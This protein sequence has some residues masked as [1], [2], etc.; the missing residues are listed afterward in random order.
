MDAPFELQALRDLREI[1][2]AIRDLQS[3]QAITSKRFKEG[4]KLLQ[5]E[6]QIV[7]SQLND[8]TPTMDGTKAWETRN[9]ILRNLINNPRLENIPEE[10]LV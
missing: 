8:G 5:N 10:N 4:I 1:N 3:Q 9:P 7:E 2:L 6:A